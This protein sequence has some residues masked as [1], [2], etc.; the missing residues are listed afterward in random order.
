MME[1]GGDAFMRYAV[2]LGRIFYS[3][4]FILSSVKHFSDSYVVHA[5]NAG[6]PWAAVLVPLSGIVIL[7][8]GVNLL[9]GNQVRGSAWLIV[10]FLV[11]TTLIIHRFWGLP[12]PQQAMEQQIHFMKNLAMLGTA[13][14][15]GYF[16]AGPLSVDSWK[17]RSDEREKVAPALQGDPGRVPAGTGGR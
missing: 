10:L 4:I 11:P 16:G 5:A 6:T 15:L 17:R 2:L 14:L 7:V 1:E 9:L 12:D 8:G 3:A 13:L